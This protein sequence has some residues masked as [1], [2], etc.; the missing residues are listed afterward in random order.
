MFDLGAGHLSQIL[1]APSSLS[2]SHCA[3]SGS[4]TF[5]VVGISSSQLRLLAQRDWDE[6][7][8]GSP[9]GLEMPPRVWSPACLQVGA[10]R[11]GGVLPA[12]LPLTLQLSH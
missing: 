5:Q 2:Q 11:G 6:D 9:D 1:L 7:G 12:D 8:H 3:F 4:L 10:G